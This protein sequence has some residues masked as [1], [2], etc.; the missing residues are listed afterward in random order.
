VGETMAQPV[1]GGL[2]EQVRVYTAR[3][4]ALGESDPRRALELCNQAARL[5]DQIQTQTT[6]LSL[7]AE[8]HYT[9]ASLLTHLTDFNQA[10]DEGFQAL[11]GFE[12]AGNSHGR[13]RTLVLLAQIHYCLN[14]L[15]HAL[16]L[17]YEARDLS[18]ILKMEDTVA[19]INTGIGSI[20][21]ETG[22][23]AESLD[24]FESARR[25]F[26]ELGDQAGIAAT[27]DSVCQAY[28]ELE[29]APAAVEAGMRALQIYETLGYRLGEAS[30]ILRIGEVHFRLGDQQQAE[31]FYQS[32]IEITG[33]LSCAHLELPARL[34]LAQIVAAKGDYSRALNRMIETLNLAEEKCLLGL[35]C[36]IHQALAETYKNLG[37]FR[38]A[39]LHFE[40][41]HALQENMHQDESEARLQAMQVSHG[42]ESARKEAEIYQLRNVKLREEIEERKRIESELKVRAITDDLTGSYNRRY[43][44]E[45]AQKELERI[46]RYPHPLS[47][48]IFDLDHFKQVNDQYG[49][50]VGDEVL[51]AVVQCAKGCLRSVDILARYGGEEF[52]VLLPE[53]DTDKAAF[54]AERLRKAMRSQAFEVAGKRFSITASFGVAGVEDTPPAKIDDLLEKADQ[55]LLTAKRAGRNRVLVWQN[56]GEELLKK[57]YSY[58]DLP[59]M[60]NNNPV[61]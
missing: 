34:R 29:D 13:A 11:S 37:D 61:L 52:V 32:C 3:A 44:Y 6:T 47:L 50:L 28:T 57:P 4:Y 42:L 9:H 12:Q 43:W 53:T 46:S 10:L 2:E 51:T 23:P 36:Q 60:G 1:N 19:V 31:R 40:R 49:H 48:I 16:Q 5:C 39:L 8:V 45:L 20:L 25:I 41:H 15:S 27:Y 59:T 30:A 17:Y 55:A 54:L 58:P 24:L 38:T 21:I 22:S 18:R 26:V 33:D 35:Q 56:G 14:D 7:C